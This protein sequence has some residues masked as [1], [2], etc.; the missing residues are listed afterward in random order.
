MLKRALIHVENTEKLSELARYLV[1]ADWTLL[2]ANKT[3]EYLK[4]EKIPVVREQALVESNLYMNDTSQLL[5]RI[6]QTKFNEPAEFIHHVESADNNIFLVCMNV[7][8]ESDSYLVNKL[9]KG[10]QRPISYY[11]ADVLRTAFSNFENVLILTDPNDYKEAIVQLKTDNITDE[12]RLYLAAKAMNL[13]S[14]YDGAIAS[15]IL[16]HHNYHQTFLN[17]LTYPF[18]NN[19]HLQM[20]SNTQQKAALFTMPEGH[21]SLGSGALE[22]NNREL[23][24]NMASDISLVW[25]QIC[26]LFQNLKNQPTVKSTN[27]DGYDFTTQFTPLTGNVFTIAIKFNIIVGAAISPSAA[28]SFNK[29]MIFDTENIKNYTLGCSAVVDAQAAREISKYN[30]SAIVAPDFTEEAKAILK[31]KKS[32]R[33][34]PTA[35]VARS[36][37]VGQ[38]VNGGILLQTKDTVLFN[39]WNV[40]TKNRPSQFKSDEMAFGTMLTMSSRSYSAVLLKNNAIVGL[41]QGC[42]S[43]AKAIGNALF[44][45]RETCE[46]MKNLK[47]QEH[48]FAGLEAYQNDEAIA[49]VLIC[50][51]EIPFSQAIRDLIDQGVTAIIQTG[52]TPSDNEF[53]NYCD[54]RGIVMVFTGMSHLNI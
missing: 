40:K 4:Q 2:S 53:I 36:N 44:D 13:V 24:Y 18:K 28:E 29:T 42:T 8:P 38:F 33:L 5:K 52:G 9:L 20:G 47:N 17:Y 32:I 23:D 37:Y 12:F 50:D 51:S 25:E 26:T 1:S 3:E 35:K 48:Q 22:I 41:S 19:A 21:S 14:A 10:Q 30:A 54:E 27:S 7:I 49:D 16:H 43:T 6:T 11:I 31:E 39:Q 34:V 15:S 45:A 46:R